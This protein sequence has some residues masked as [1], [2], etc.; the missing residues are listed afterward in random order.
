MV[1]SWY[2]ERLARTGT[3][4]DNEP[5]DRSTSQ[6]NIC[7]VNS[8]TNI[9][10]RDRWKGSPMLDRTPRATP[11]LSYCMGCCLNLVDG[12]LCRSPQASPMPKLVEAEEAEDASNLHVQLHGEQVPV[13]LPTDLSTSSGRSS[14]RSSQDDHLRRMSSTPGTGDILLRRS[15][16]ISG[17][18]CI[19]GR[20]SPLPCL[21]CLSDFCSHCLP[22]CAV[23]VVSMQLVCPLSHMNL[24]M[25][26]RI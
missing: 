11:R 12:M 18:S 22:E 20:T 13:H 5:L 2:A 24:G 14:R 4:G 25:C 16:G 19:S 9:G 21:C 6:N 3:E 23:V 10:K 26:G 8:T 7:R 17:E 15:S 1:N